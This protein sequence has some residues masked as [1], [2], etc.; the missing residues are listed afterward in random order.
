MPHSSPA[1]QPAP[2]PITAIYPGTFDPLTLGHE[3]L[4]ARASALFDTLVIAVAAAHHKKTLFTLP[5][6]LA[7]AQHSAQHLPAPLAARVRVLP[8]EGLI[9]HFALS[10]GA[11][12]IVR[13]LR[14]AADL[15]FEMPMAGM[16]AELAPDV[17]TI[18]LPTDTRWRN[19]SSTLVREIALLGGDAAPFVAPH[20]W[21]A[22]QDK[23]LA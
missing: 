18:F 22:L 14:G 4:I 2:G 16:N 1:P 12:V 17:Q 23:R 3:S 11:Q 10:Q 20:I 7:L 15:D 19:V 13:G 21:Q 6:R 5:E 8:F 9:T